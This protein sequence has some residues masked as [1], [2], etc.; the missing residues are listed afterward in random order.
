MTEEQIKTRSGLFIIISHL[1]I[2]IP[3]VIILYLFGG[4]LFEEMTTAI[5][6]IAPMF[7]A[8]STAIIN[9]IISNRKK[10]KTKQAEDIT[11]EFIFITFLLPSLFI[12]YIISIVLLKAF[13]IG[14]S[15]FEQF[16]IMLTL[17]ETAFGIYA[18]YV[19][20]SLFNIE[21]YEKTNK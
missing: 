8:Y 9:Y 3:L 13:N 15:T 5:A 11:N 17:G 2:I 1:V 10:K 14:F 16:K 20:K 21:R 18:G 12:I 7:S 4:F 19:L 6:L